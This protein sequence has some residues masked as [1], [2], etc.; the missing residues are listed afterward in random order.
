MWF[1]LR[2]WEFDWAFMLSAW[3]ANL[4]MVA[5]LSHFWPAPTPQLSLSLI[6]PV[7]VCVCVRARVLCVFVRASLCVCVCVLVCVT[8]QILYLSIAWCVSTLGRPKTDQ[9]FA[10][11]LVILSTVAYCGIPFVHEFVWRA[12]FSLLL[13]FSLPLWS[14]ATGG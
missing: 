7:C 12:L 10:Q 8:T 14:R 9:K 4:N 11:N 2:A 5:F 3:E 13:C 1:S 6:L